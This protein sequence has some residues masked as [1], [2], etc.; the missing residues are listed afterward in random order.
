MQH[1]CQSALEAE[2][3]ALSSALKTFLPIKWMIQEM[4]SNMNGIELKA[5]N[6]N[7]TVFEDNQSACILA[8]TQRIANRTEC[9]LSKWHW[10]WDK[11]NEKE[12]TIVKCP[13][14]LMMADYL[15]SIS[16]SG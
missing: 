7:T 14:K 10:F 2:H 3:S 16:N 8:T 15:T 5:I 11:C 12:F 9:L 6:S 13:S 4:M 1:I